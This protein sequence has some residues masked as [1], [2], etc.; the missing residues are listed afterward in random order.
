MSENDIIMQINHCKN[1]IIRLNKKYTDKKRSS[2]KEIEN[3][4][5]KEINKLINTKK[6][7][8]RN[9]KDKQM[10]KKLKSEIRAMRK[11]KSIAIK[12][13]LKEIKKERRKNI[14]KIKNEIKALKTALTNIRKPSISQRHF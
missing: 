4:L 5:N 8:T 9:N 6:S 13:T 1:E 3:S 7:F 2:R 14:K 10:V 11:A 12:N